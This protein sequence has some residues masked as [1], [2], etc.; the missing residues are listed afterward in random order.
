M[1]SETLVFVTALAMALLLGC[2]GVSGTV[3]TLV[4]KCSETIWPG[5]LA[6]SGGA[7]L[8]D[9][10]FAL[11][12]GKS[13]APLNAPTGWS[14]R[15]WGRTGC[16]FNTSG[17]GSCA[18]G[19]CFHGLKCSGSGG[20]PPA[21][22]VEFTI[23]GYGGKDFYDVSLVDGY[24]V[25]LSVSAAGGTGDCRTAGC[26]ADLR[27]SCPAELSVKGSDGRVIACRSACNAFGT[28]EYCCTGDH[29]NPQTCSP[30]KYSKIFKAACPTAY[31][32]AYDDASSLVTCSQAHYTITFCPSVAAC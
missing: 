7:S 17:E 21:T 13:S 1:A 30:N 24:N 31:S 26:N 5:V 19:D 32:Y 11:S 25:P 4:N 8:A 9:G 2:D 29:G 15:F 10:G 28:P 22:L 14:G 23:G 20:V 6:G 16:A 3:F 12:T 27:N 18:T